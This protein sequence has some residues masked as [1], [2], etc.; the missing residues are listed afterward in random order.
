M[1]NVMSKYS[2]MIANRHTAVTP[3]PVSAPIPG[4]EKDMQVNSTGGYTFSVGDWGQFDRFLI[5]G[6]AG[7]SYYAS[8]KKLVTDNVDV[9]KRCIKAD[10]VRAV[11]RIVAIS[12]AGRAPKNDPALFALALCFCAD[13]ESTR[14][15]AFS[16]LNAVA[17]TGTHLLHFVDYLFGDK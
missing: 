17:R 10:G 3:A 13:E 7:N 8:Q 15:Y 16:K 6:A 11:N 1:E 2:K 9:I 14:K 12:Q 4:R 5:L